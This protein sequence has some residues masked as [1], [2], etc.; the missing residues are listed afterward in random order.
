MA[1]PLGIG[2][3][4]AVRHPDA[5]PSRAAL[6]AASSPEP[7]F[8]PGVSTAARVPTTTGSELGRS[9]LAAMTLA[10]RP[11]TSRTST[12][13]TARRDPTEASNRGDWSSSPKEWSSIWVRKKPTTRF[14]VRKLR[15]AR[16]A[17]TSQSSP[18]HQSASRE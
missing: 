6:D 17:W 13:A 8:T 1:G 10:R 2:P 12:A 7:K 15:Q 3:P 11:H 14:R 9:A 16:R 4:L 5:V 18:R